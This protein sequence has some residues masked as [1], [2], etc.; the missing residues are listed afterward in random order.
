MAKAHSN[1]ASMSV[2]ALLKLRDE[3][4]A[5]LGRKAHDLKQQLSRLTGGATENGRKKGRASLKGRKVPPKYRDP[6]SGQTW[7]AR[8]AQ[9]VWLRDAIK[10]GAKLEDFAIAH[11]AKSASSRKK[12][13][14]K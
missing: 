12:K 7:A 5:T 2:D 14:R 8:G 11:A 9:P 1:L 3:I 6:K 10:G 4:G 13:S